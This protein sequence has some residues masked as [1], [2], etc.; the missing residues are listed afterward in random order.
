MY[1]N[2]E[3]KDNVRMQESRRSLRSES[4]IGFVLH[5]IIGVIFA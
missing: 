2:I 5:R 1:N 3:F 4:T